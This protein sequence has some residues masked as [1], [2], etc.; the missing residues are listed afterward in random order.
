MSF[1]K[2]ANLI[3]CRSSGGPGG[4]TIKA[5]SYQSHSPPETYLRG[6]PRSLLN[7]HSSMASLPFGLLQAA[8]QSPTLSPRFF[9]FSKSET[10]GTSLRASTASLATS[11]TSSPSSVPAGMQFLK[12]FQVFASLFSFYRLNFV[13]C[14]LFQCIVAEAIRKRRKESGSITLT[15]M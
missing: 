12:H 3:S 6:S 2:S 1:I 10:L 15:E 11:A 4:S 13:L 14:L 7:F 9:S 8:S 5:G